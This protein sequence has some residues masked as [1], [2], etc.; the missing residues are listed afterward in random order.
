MQL[1]PATAA[2]L[3]VTDRTDPTQSVEGG[4]REMA[5]LIGKYHGDVPMALAAYNAGEGNVAKYGGIPPFKETQ[6]YIP[7][8]LGYMQQ[9]SQAAPVSAEG[10]AGLP[11]AGSGAA[12]SQAQQTVYLQSQGQQPQVVAQ[13]AAAAPAALPD[14]DATALPW[15]GRGQLTP[16]NQ[17]QLAGLPLSGSGILFPSVMQPPDSV[18]VGAV[19]QLVKSITGTSDLKKATGILGIGFGALKGAS[20]GTGAGG[21]GGVAGLGGL[22]NLSNLKGFFGI[23]TKPDN[24]GVLAQ[25]GIAPPWLPGQ[26]TTFKSV[27]TSPAVGALATAGGLALYNQGLQKRNTA[28]TGLGGGL[29][30]AGLALQSP[31]V[32]AAAGGPV[33]AAGAGLAIGGGVGLLSSGLQKGGGA[34]VGLDVAGGALTGA[35]IGFLVGGPVG[36]LIGA[37]IGAAAGAVAGLIRLG[38]KTETEKI[39]AQIKQ[40][41]GIDIKD[42]KIVAQIKQI[43]DQN[44][45]GNVAVGIRSQQVQDIIRLYALSTGQAA[46]LP[47]PEYSATITQSAASGNQLQQVYQGGQLVQNPYSGPTTYQYQT[48]VTN[49]SGAQ[50]RD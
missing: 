5:R 26:S 16:I 4:A 13:P 27:A 45:G 25:A 20:G 3:G 24:T 14:Q 18:T 21:K 40:V 12:V 23:G 19:P 22:G 8:V 11:P 48:A 9:Y 7:K 10:Y 17:E 50:G 46:G 1:M 33:A 15:G 2:A 35:G 28:A 6:A 47:R 32:I 44:Y 37:G 30:G 34:G 29:A 31:Q 42:L 43:I 36:A 38:I 39:Q 41:Y 49:G